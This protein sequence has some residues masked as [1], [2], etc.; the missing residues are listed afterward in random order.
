V[1]INIADYFQ[2]FPNTSNSAQ[3]LF[4]SCS[5]SKTLLSGFLRNEAVNDNRKKT[6]KSILYSKS[7]S[8]LTAQHRHALN[9]GWSMQFLH[10]GKGSLSSAV[11]WHGMM[12]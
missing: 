5:K 3:E 1:F 8:M 6:E 9:L 11:G 2:N 10:F 12:L 4:T 7:D